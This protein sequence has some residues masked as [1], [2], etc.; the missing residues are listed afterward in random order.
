MK[1]TQ[2]I[3]FANFVRIVVIN[4]FR[5][6]TKYMC[7]KILQNFIIAKYLKCKVLLFMSFYGVTS[8]DMHK[9]SWSNT[10]K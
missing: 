10:L 7:H 3:F 8:T 6:A 4:L 9:S 5:C 1:G 2:M